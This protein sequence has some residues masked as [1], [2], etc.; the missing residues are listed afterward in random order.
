MAARRFPPRSALFLDVLLTAGFVQVVFFFSKNYVV[1]LLGA[2]FGVISRQPLP[3]LTINTAMNFGFLQR[4]ATKLGPSAPSRSVSSASSCGQKIGSLVSASLGSL[5]ALDLTHSPFTVL[6]W[7]Q[8]LGF[9]GLALGSVWAGSLVTA[10]EDR[11]STHNAYRFVFLLYAVIAAFKIVLSLCMSK[12]AELNHPPFLKPGP[13]GSDSP[14]PP[15]GIYGGDDDDF[16]ERRPLIDRTK[17]STP[18]VDD[19][20]SKFDSPEDPTDPPATLPLPQLVFVCFLFSMDSFASSLIPGP[21]ESLYRSYRSK[22]TT[23]P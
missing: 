16:A 4:P 13:V 21:L 10:L 23:L 19:G 20:I 11:H 18:C 15:D 9:V 5:H 17:S 8:V 2:I 22:L 7:Y 6:V 14:P 3:L 1:L 12:Y